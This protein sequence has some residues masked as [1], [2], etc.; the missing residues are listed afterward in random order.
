MVLK[1]MKNLL[2]KNL[3]AVILILFL[4]SGVYAEKIVFSAG[5][6]TGKT[7]DKSSRT[8]L[9]GNA[10]ILTESMEI[11]AD[12]IELSGDDY[13][14]IKADGK[15][16]GKNLESK[17]E[18]TC[19]SLE[20][21]R[22]TKIAL[23]NGNVDLTDVDNDVKAKAQ[24]IEY[25]QDKDIAVLQIDINLTQKDNVC[26]GAYAIY[27]KKD[28][29]LEISGNAQVRQSDDTFRAQNIVFNMD[30]EEITLGGNV[31]GSVKDSKKSK[32]TE[33]SD[34]IIVSSEENDDTEYEESK[35]EASDD[36]EEKS[37]SGDSEQSDDK[38]K[39]SK[40]IIKKRF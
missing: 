9:K 21:D 34:A 25:D 28:Q 40:T 39:D 7:G 13:R 17:M 6:M 19:D 31:K 8:Y 29:L 37:E 3:L 30:T 23:L 2:S 10:Y 22:T 20:F 35:N 1:L 16:T 36:K 26:S 38:S 18:F 27:H 32:T 5:S 15:I 11:R 24:R 33:S 12:S 14:Y 4:F